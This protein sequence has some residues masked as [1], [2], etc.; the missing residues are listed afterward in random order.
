M[1]FRVSWK[2][3]IF[4]IIAGWWAIALYHEAPRRRGGL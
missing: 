4:F 2:M 3:A 1:F